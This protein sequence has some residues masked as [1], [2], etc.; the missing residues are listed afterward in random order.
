M[1]VYRCDRCKKDFYEI[2]YLSYWTVAM[3]STNVARLELCGPCKDHIFK[4]VRA[5]AHKKEQE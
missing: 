3:G 2:D 1:I 4:E 5:Y